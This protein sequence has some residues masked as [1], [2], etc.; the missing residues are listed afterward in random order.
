MLSAWIRRRLT[1]LRSNICNPDLRKCLCLSGHYILHLSVIP[2]L[3]Q[4]T[5][6]ILLWPDL[7]VLVLCIYFFLV[8]PANKHTHHT[9][10]AVSTEHTHTIISYKCTKK[11]R[12]FSWHCKSAPVMYSDSTRCQLQNELHLFSSTQGAM[13]ERMRPDSG[14]AP[15]SQGCGLAWQIQHSPS[16]KTALGFYP[17]LVAVFKLR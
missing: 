5:S 6:G 8:I 4:L 12:V 9:L 13:H 17:R 3:L 1:E 16:A 11:V 2:S 15:Q 10:P 7:A 14:M